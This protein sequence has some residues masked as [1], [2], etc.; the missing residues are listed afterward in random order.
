MGSD[1]YYS[2]DVDMG[3]HTI[4]AMKKC[5]ICKIKFEPT[6]PPQA[7]CDYKCGLEDARLKREKKI[8]RE[9]RQYKQ[10][11][12]KL[13]EHVS[14]AQKAINSYVRI[15]DHKLG[16]ISCGCGTSPQFDAG[17]YLSRGAH[18]NHRFNLNNIFKQCVKCNRYRGGNYSEMRK[19]VIERI[20]IEK[21]EALE[22]DNKIKR[23]SKDYCERIKRIFNKKTRIAKKRLG[24]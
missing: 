16:C 20:G 10:A 12:K 9:T 11:N 5:R 2:D 4:R 22:N 3:R 23:F 6:R 7:V 21:V 18:P 8:S 1:R 24:I 14:D 15:R 19:G 17:H 13:S